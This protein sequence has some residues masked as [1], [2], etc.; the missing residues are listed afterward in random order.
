MS[1][2]RII[3]GLMT[4]L[5]TVSG[6]SRE[7]VFDYEPT[8]INPQSKRPVCYILFDDMTRG[9]GAKPSVGQVVKVSYSILVRVCFLWL[10][11]EQAEKE[12]LPFLNSIPA[13]ID[14]DPRL[15]TMLN[16][17]NAGYLG[18]LAFIGSSQGVFVT[19]GKTQYRAIDFQLTAHEKF[20]Y[21]LAG[22]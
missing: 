18:G 15:A 1:Y 9:D 3:S 17:D 22:H 19:I 7:Q 14:H 10:D 11:N 6:L 8:A 16:G 5:S 21:G 4:N 12:I 2:E 13:C 20:Q